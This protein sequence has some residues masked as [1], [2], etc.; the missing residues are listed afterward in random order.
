MATITID[1]ENVVAVLCAIMRGIIST[2]A[3]A[4]LDE[5]TGESDAGVEVGI[6]TETAPEEMVGTGKGGTSILIGPTPDT[7]CSV[8]VLHLVTRSCVHLGA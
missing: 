4:L 2:V 5:T 6:M 1:N 8:F 3:S 7:A